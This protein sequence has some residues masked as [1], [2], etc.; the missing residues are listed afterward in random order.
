MR[1]LIAG[2]VLAL[3]MF[4]GMGTGVAF[5]DHDGHGNGPWADVD[6]VEDPDTSSG[7]P[8]HAY[9]AWSGG[10]DFSPV[11]R[12]I[13]DQGLENGILNENAQ[14][15]PS[16]RLSNNPNCPFHWAPPAP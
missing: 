3:V 16:V 14:G 1:K 5:A 9:Q 7:P 8:L 11:G 10:V 15:G 2:A 12:N 6:D 13:S 4:G